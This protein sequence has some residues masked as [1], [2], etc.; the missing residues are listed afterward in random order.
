MKECLPLLPLAVGMGAAKLRWTYCQLVRV[1]EVGMDVDGD[2]RPDLDPA[3]IYYFRQSLGGIYG[4][5]FLAVEPNVHAGVP[6]V[7]GGSF[8]NLLRL[9]PV[10]RPLVGLALALRVPS[11]INIGGIEF[12]ENLPLLDQPPVSNTVPGAI[13]IQEVLEWAEWIQQA[14]DAVAL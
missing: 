14:G 3:R 10:G 9:S 2:T 12:D 6:N 13:A 1:I 7:A 11:L 5:L 4:A 8:V